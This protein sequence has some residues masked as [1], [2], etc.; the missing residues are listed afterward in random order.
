MPRI[1]LPF[2]SIINDQIS[3]TGDKARYLASVLRCEKGDE[4][5]I[6]DGEGSCFRS[7]IVKSGKREVVAATLERFSSDLESPLD[8]VLVQGVL[9]GEKMD[10][11]IQKTTELGVKGIIP[12]ITARSQVRETRKIARW[13]K[14]A[15]EASR[16]SGRSA[17]PVVHEVEMFAD[18][19]S[20]HSMQTSGEGIIFYEEGGMRLSETIQRMK[21]RRVSDSISSLA[22]VVGP[23]GGF[24]KEEVKT[25][26]ER[27]FFTASLGRR[28][29]RAETAA[30]SAVA[31]VQFSFGDMS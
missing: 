22:V 6:F 17:A 14:I 19:F 10:L 25:A 4:L 7:V 18:L 8:I 26:E 2:V 11:V 12:V 29:L 13:K 30:I 16:Q 20:D 31:L 3:I 24:T 27:G 1:Y 5:I 28:V 21:M 15:E 23:E 9:K